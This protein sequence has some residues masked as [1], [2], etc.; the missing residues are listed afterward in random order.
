MPDN[1]IHL[2]ALLMEYKELHSDDNLKSTKK[3]CSKTKKV[4]KLCVRDYLKV[5]KNL[6]VYGTASL[7]IILMLTISYVLT[8]L[9][10]LN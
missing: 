10:L 9:I 8:A 1:T 6:I 3:H 2:F 5:L 4:N 7:S